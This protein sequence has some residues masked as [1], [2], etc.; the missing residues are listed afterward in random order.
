M[1]RE[2]G[3]VYTQTSGIYGLEALIVPPEQR[4]K[5]LPTGSATPLSLGGTTWHHRFIECV[6]RGIHSDLKRAS[7]R[8][9][10]VN[11]SFDVVTE[12]VEYWACAASRIVF[13]N[14]LQAIVSRS[15][16]GD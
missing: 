4:L 8:F 9:E 10:G 13:L 5:R 2:N 7:S 1:E 14:F 15:T 3:I 12:R 16:R 6:S 11:H